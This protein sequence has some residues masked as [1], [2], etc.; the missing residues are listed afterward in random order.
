MQHEPF[1]GETSS[2]QTANHGEVFNTQHKRSK[3]EDRAKTDK[4][5]CKN[6]YA[7]FANDEINEKQPKN[8]TGQNSREKR[9]KIGI[10]KGKGIEVG[11]CFSPRIAVGVCKIHHHTCGDASKMSVSMGKSRYQNRFFF[12]A[13]LL[14]LSFCF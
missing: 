6:G 3:R 9:S 2:N 13:H 1:N 7:V 14:H 8:E 12:I 5:F 4:L 11:I 10:T